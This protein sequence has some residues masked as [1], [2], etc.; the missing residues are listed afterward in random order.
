[1][2][3]TLTYRGKTKP[4]RMWS[5]ELGINYGT[6]LARINHGWSP[7]KTLT[8]QPGEITANRK[9][10]RCG[11]KEY[12]AWLAMKARC[13]DDRRHNAHRYSAEESPFA[14]DGT[15]HSKCFSKT[16]ALPL[17]RNTRLVGSTMTRIMKQGTVAGRQQKSRQ[18]I[19]L[20]LVIAETAPPLLQ[21]SL[22]GRGTEIKVQD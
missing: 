9:H 15:T 3:R 4:L 21:G 22:G 19:G 16:L 5:E 7:Q 14:I 6:L 10:G 1:M 8:I 11:T 18:G 17:Q 12:R 2:R 13:S 20:R